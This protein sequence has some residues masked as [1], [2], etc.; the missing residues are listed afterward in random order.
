MSTYLDE[1]LTNLASAIEELDEAYQNTLFFIEVSSPDFWTDENLF[2]AIDKILILLST[3]YEETD[4]IYSAL[5][6]KLGYE[7]LVNFLWNK[8]SLFRV[9]FDGN[10]TFKHWSE[11]YHEDEYNNFIDAKIN[12]V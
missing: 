6:K 7:R 9:K 4:A 5:C 10:N 1:T 3:R 11:K 2:R 8:A 12:P